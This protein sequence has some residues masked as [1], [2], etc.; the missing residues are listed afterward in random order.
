MARV[1]F[2]LVLVAV[3]AVAGC[4]GGLRPPAESGHLLFVRAAGGFAALPYASEGPSFRAEHAV[5][6]PDFS[7]V[8]T[9]DPRG[10]TTVVRRLDRSGNRLDRVVLEGELVPRVVSPNGDLVAL[11]APRIA[12][13]APYVPEARARTNLAVLDAGADP[14]GRVREFDLDGNFEPEAFSTDNS[15]LFVIEFLPAVDPERYRV[16]RLRLADGRVMPIGRLKNAAPEQMQGTGRTQVYSPAADELYTL[17]TQQTEP[18]HAADH[19][20]E[21]AFVHLL[22]LDEK[23]A[24]CIDLPREFGGGSATASAL[25]TSPQGERLYVADWSNGVVAI[26]RPYRLRVA[27]TAR[28]EFGP[29]DDKTFARATR[30]RLYVPPHDTVV[31]L[32]LP[33]LRPVARWSLGGEIEGLNVGPDGSE[34]YV[35]IAGNIK[36]LDA[37]TGAVLDSVAVSGAAAI[38][39]VAP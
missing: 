39:Y 34:I 10:G 38:E 3:L 11:G 16:R 24:H 37:V 1:R 26:V 2:S 19:R 4:G 33:T 28:I 29:P 14:G 17:Y 20:G 7:V 9:A 32:D 12:D 6:A 8:A 5:A 18:G 22:N 36:K 30:D 13:G 31:V 27:R 21:S 25:A 23:W 15:E 35:S